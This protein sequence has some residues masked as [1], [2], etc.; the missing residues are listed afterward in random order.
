MLI[1][2]G[3]CI[4]DCALPVVQVDRIVHSHE[5]RQEYMEA[6]LTEFSRSAYHC[7][8]AVLLKITVMECLK[9]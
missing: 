4:T 3:L 9:T 5:K 6:F 1:V 7:N 8:S 2:D